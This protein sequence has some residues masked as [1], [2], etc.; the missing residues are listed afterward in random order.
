MMTCSARQDTI[1]AGTK[2]ADAVLAKLAD[3][4]TSITPALDAEVQRALAML[5]RE[6]GEPGL[7]RRV[8][9]I[10]TILFTMCQARRNGR[11][12]LFA[13]QQLRVRRLAAA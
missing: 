2:A 5:R 3:A 11:A 9:Q 12:N 10:S 7:V 13:S 6:G 1:P 4:G 8:E